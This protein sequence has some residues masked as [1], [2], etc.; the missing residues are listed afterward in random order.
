MERALN[1]SLRDI[2]QVIILFMPKGQRG[3]Q[4]YLWRY[5]VCHEIIPFPMLLHFKEIK[6]TDLP[7]AVWQAGFHNPLSVT[8]RA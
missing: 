8:A 5:L 3:F 6:V 4:R 7:F 1:I 2:G